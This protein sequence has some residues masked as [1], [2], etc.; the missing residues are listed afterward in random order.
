MMPIQYLRMILKM[1]FGTTY[2]LRTQYRTLCPRASA[3]RQVRE[4]TRPYRQVA[5]NYYPLTN[6]ATAHR[7][8]RKDSSL[9]CRILQQTA[10]PNVRRNSSMRNADAARSL[11]I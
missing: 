5:I 7:N 6:G 10:M 2:M 11:T 1:A 4:C 3:Y 9:T 8:G